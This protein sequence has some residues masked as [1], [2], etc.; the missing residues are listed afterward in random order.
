[1]NPK[2][3]EIYK[4]RSVRAYQPKE[5]PEALVRDLLQAGMAA[6]SAV[7]KDPWRFVVVTRQDLL[8]RIAAYLPNG[9]MLARA[10]VGLVVCGS[11]EDAHDRQESYMLQDC[12]A[13]IE[14]VLVAASMLGLGA[15]WLGVH[16]RQERIDG[17]RAVLKVPAGI[18]PLAVIAVGWPA[19][20]KAPRTRYDESKVIWESW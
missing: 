19:E 13:A 12:S 16:P 15:C 20:E 6:P 14:N 2:L 17:I 7:V 9:K 4:R 10:A 1:M 3:S 5:V 18:I 8:E 11:I